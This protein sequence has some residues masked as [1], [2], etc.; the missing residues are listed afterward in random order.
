MTA[1]TPN[2][3]ALTYLPICAPCVRGEGSECHTP[4]CAL[5]LRDVPADGL[6]AEFALD[7]DT[8]AVTP[9]REALVRSLRDARSVHSIEVIQGGVGQCLE[10]GEILRVVYG[11]DGQPL[12]NP[13]TEHHLKAQADALIASGAVVPLDTLADDEA[14]LWAIA[15][16]DYDMHAGEGAGDFDDD[17]VTQAEQTL[18]AL[19]AALSERGDR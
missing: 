4:G 14:L 5:F 11:E 12:F 15:R 7:I 1:V 13:F 19:A 3:E 6:I 9:S 2:R 8:L 16:N 17:W 10:C 18:R